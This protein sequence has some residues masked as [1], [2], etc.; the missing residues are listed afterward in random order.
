MATTA[1]TNWDDEDIDQGSTHENNGE[2][3]QW[4]TTTQSDNGLHTDSGGAEL[5]SLQSEMR[6]LS[7]A[8]DGMKKSQRRLDFRRSPQRNSLLCPVSSPRHEPQMPLAL[9][10]ER[11]PSKGYPTWRMWQQH[12]RSVARADGWS[13][14]KSLQ[15]LA[16][17]LSGWA[18]DEFLS[19]PTGCQEDLDEM[20]KYLKTRS[21]PY[22]NERISRGEIKSLFQGAE[23]TLS[24][25]A[26]RL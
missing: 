24:E 17:S 10:P 25:F 9:H 21:S 22:R 3:N 6:E 20:L 4:R 7:V 5:Q 1:K 2:T 14:R 12:F 23:E 11:F 8:L 26:R 16:A 19:A 15:V 18:S 13:E